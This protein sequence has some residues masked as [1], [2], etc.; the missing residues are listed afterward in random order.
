VDTNYV[1]VLGIDVGLASTGF[2]VVNIQRD[3]L[4]SLPELEI[5]KEVNVVAAG[6]IS[7]K[8]D[9][10]AGTKKSYDYARRIREMVVVLKSMHDKF[11]FP[12]YETVW[13]CET[14]TLFGR[15]LNAASVETKTAYGAVIGLSAA[16]GERFIPV[17]PH[18][19]KRLTIG[20]KDASKEEVYAIASERLEAAVVEHYGWPKSKQEH[21]GDAFSVAVAGL[22]QYSRLVG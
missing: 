22:V 3:R 13:A 16:L 7:S 4:F 10:A 17:H 21:V 12:V 20:R 1:T 11:A 6:V 9:N 19:G 2:V 14:F 18:E 15:S 8:P 5:A